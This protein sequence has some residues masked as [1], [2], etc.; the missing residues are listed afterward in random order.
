MKDLQR[1]DALRT[2]GILNEDEFS[3][4]RQRLLAKV[5]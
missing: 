5:L 2:A 3:S 1:L 4:A